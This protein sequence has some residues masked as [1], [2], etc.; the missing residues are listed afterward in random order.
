[1]PNGNGAADVTAG[2][3]SAGPRPGVTWTSYQQPMTPPAGADTGQQPTA[4]AATAQ[5]L[6]SQMPLIGRSGSNVQRGLSPLARCRPIQIGRPLRPRMWPYRAEPSRGLSGSRCPVGRWSVCRQPMNCRQAGA[7]RTNPCGSGCG[8]EGAESLCRLPQ[9]L[10]MVHGLR[11]VGRLRLRRRH[12]Q[13]R[14]GRRIPRGIRRTW[15][16]RKAAT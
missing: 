10:L 6:P 2:S 14:P 11:H 1:M 8:T 15:P 16:A 3:A 9:L 4:T 13:Q 12:C 7:L 5:D